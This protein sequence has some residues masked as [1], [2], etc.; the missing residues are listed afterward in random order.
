MLY[1]CNSQ[2]MSEVLPVPG[3]PERKSSED[4]LLM[5]PSK[6]A[7]SPPLIQG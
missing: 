7:R 6:Y 2:R 4:V 3:G 1:S 5:K